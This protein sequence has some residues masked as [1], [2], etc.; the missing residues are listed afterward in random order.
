MAS[1]ALLALWIFNFSHL[2]AAESY[3]YT[4]DF[5]LALWTSLLSSAIPGAAIICSLRAL[6][7]S[8]PRP[9]R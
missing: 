2:P 4:A 7:R 3:E 5:T 8:S 6:S 1:L 9:R